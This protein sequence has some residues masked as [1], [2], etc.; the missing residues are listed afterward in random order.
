MFRLDGEIRRGEL[1]FSGGNDRGIR[2]ENARVCFP[3]E[4]RRGEEELDIARVSR[5]LGGYRRSV[6][7]VRER[8]GTARVFVQSERGRDE[9]SEAWD[10]FRGYGAKDDWERFR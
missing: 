2:R 10:C 5:G 1:R 8:Y 9:G 3:D 4:F 7:Y 6:E